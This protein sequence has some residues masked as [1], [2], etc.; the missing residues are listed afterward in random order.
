MAISSVAFLGAT[1]HVPQVF[2]LGITIMQHVADLC[3]DVVAVFNGIS[4]V[5]MLVREMGL[6]KRP[7]LVVS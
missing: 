6:L 3:I 2:S 7:G 1:L 4:C 5:N